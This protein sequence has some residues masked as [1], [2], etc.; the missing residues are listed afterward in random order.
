M[1]L[2]REKFPKLKSILQTHLENQRDV[3]ASTDTVNANDHKLCWEKFFEQDFVKAF[4][5]NKI[6]KKGFYD[7]EALK[8]S[9]GYPQYDSF[10][11][12]VK[13]FRTNFE[14]SRDISDL[15][16]QCKD[17]H[18]RLIALGEAL[19]SFLTLF[20]FK[21]IIEEIHKNSANAGSS[22]GVF[23]DDHLQRILAG[24]SNIEKGFMLQAKLSYLENK[25]MRLKE[26]H[27]RFVNVLTALSEC[28]PSDSSK[29]SLVCDWESV[30][31]KEMFPIGQVPSSIMWYLDLNHQTEYERLKLKP[32]FVDT[33][34]NDYKEGQEIFNKFYEDHFKAL[35]SKLFAVRN[36]SKNPE[37]D[38]HLRKH[39]ERLI[40]ET[41]RRAKLLSNDAS[42]KSFLLSYVLG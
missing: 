15:A 21:Y 25:A 41:E 22:N 40:N 37:H 23:L 4:D 1:I 39:L 31:N 42:T 36:S 35:C 29:P 24:P 2:C 38:S 17:C 10:I 28:F 33:F 11:K 7:V 5:L 18:D 19:V 12:H 20:D 32:E 13:E 14:D 16:L 30:L 9:L 27:D 26:N 3:Y 8:E 6:S 34:D